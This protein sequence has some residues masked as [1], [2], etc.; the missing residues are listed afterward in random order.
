[1]PSLFNPYGEEK[2]VGRVKTMDLSR[3]ANIFAGE[4]KKDIHEYSHYIGLASKLTGN[5][6]MQMHRRIQKAFPTE[7]LD[8]VLARIREWVHYAEKADNKGMAF[9]GLFKKYRD[10]TA[11]R[12]L[13]QPDTNT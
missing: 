5:S 6:Y 3:F 9:N 11:K 10:D 8:Y 13:L 4:T 2:E 7:K 12:N 1:M